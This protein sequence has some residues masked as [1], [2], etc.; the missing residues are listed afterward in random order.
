MQVS[1]K[2][3]LVTSGHHSDF[4]VDGVFSTKK[5]AQRL[6]ERLKD[7][8]IEQWTLEQAQDNEER[9][10]WAT[11]IYVADCRLDK[12]YTCKSQHGELASPKAILRSVDH[13]LE[14][15]AGQSPR[16]DFITVESYVSQEHANK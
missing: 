10:A 4:H 8:P 9:D 6:Q 12:I 5:L 13:T 14:V 16:T 7:A 15:R 3:Y 2:V 11:T 1:K